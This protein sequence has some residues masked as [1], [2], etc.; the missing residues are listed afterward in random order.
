M[1]EAAA[2]FARGVTL[3]PSGAEGHFLFGCALAALGR[4]S[5]ATN[6]YAAALRLQPDFAEASDSL[7]ALSG[8][9]RASS[10]R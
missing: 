6:Q 5:P 9:A 3:E 4:S 2:C 1:Q 7:A 8:R 10:L